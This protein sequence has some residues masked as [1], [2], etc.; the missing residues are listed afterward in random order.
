[1]SVLV[2]LVLSI[3]FGFV[4]SLFGFSAT[5]LV[6]KSEGGIVDEAGL[7]L[8]VAAE[9]AKEAQHFER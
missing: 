8:H 3:L 5:N 7:E 2:S 1:M 9:R 6:V 4:F